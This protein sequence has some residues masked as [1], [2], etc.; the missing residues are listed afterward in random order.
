MNCEQFLNI[1]D[2]SINI[3][4]IRNKED[5]NES[6]IS[7]SINIDHVDLILN[8]EKYLKQKEIYYIIC[9]KGEVSEYVIRS[10]NNPNYLLINITD[11]FDNWKGPTISNI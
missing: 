7:N 2:L 5:Y 10:I 6:H 3:I 1:Y 4:D 8:Y 9:D 11:G